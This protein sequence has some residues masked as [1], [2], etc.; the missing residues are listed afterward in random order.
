[1]KNVKKLYYVNTEIKSSFWFVVQSI[2]AMVF[3]PALIAG[4]ALLY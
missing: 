4:I 3:V 1:M 2:F